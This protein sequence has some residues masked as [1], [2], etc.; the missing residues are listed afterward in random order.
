MAAGTDRH[1]RGSGAILAAM[2]PVRIAQ[3][4]R[5]VS[6]KDQKEVIRQL[7]AGEVD[8]VIGSHRVLSK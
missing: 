1:R 4:S 3:L 2:T 6:S 7:K 5:F 8:V